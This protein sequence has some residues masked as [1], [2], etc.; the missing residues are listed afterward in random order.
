MNDMTQALTA[1]DV[2]K[3]ELLAEG[4]IVSIPRPLTSKRQMTPDGTAYEQI[5]QP[6]V[7]GFVNFHLYDGNLCEKRGKKIWVETKV[8]KKTMA[9]GR[10]FIYFDMFPTAE[11]PAF[12]RKI[13]ADRAQIPNDLPAETRRFDTL[14]SI[15]GTVAFVPTSFYAD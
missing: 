9:D 4:I 7:G 15:R 11:R 12:V 10:E 1:N 13:Y 8:F 3:R 2:V 6:V 5:G 14:G